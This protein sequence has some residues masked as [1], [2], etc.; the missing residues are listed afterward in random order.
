MKANETSVAAPA[1]R[2]VHNDTT[3]EIMDWPDGCVHEIV[4]SIPFGDQYEYS[5]SLNDFGHNQ[6][7]E[8]FWEQMDFMTPHLLRILKPGRVACVHVKDRIR[9]GNVTGKGM[10]TLDPFSDECSAHF[11]QHGF[12]LMG[13]ITIDTDVVR[14][15]A[16]TYRLGYSEM[17][18]DG[19]KMGCG[20]PE[21]VLLLRKP[22][23]DKDRSYADEPVTREPDKD[24]SAGLGYSLSQWQ[25]DAAGLWRSSGD[26]L[27][28]AEVLRALP[29]DQIRSIWRE[30]SAGSIYSLNVH[31][32]K[33]QE[34]LA[35]GLLPTGWMLFAPVSR[36]PDIWSDIE[37]IRTLNT[38]NVRQGKEKHV[39]PLQLD[40]IERLIRRYSMKGEI[41]FDPF[42][43]IGSVPVQAL[44][45]GRIGWGCELSRDYFEIACGYC[46]HAA[47]ADAMPT[48]FDLAEYT[49]EDA[50]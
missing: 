1:W 34:L 11:R 2:M 6:G 15:N 48:L 17:C 13:R 18:K 16:Q 32:T 42:A 50:A 24:G 5:P 41:V 12:E 36:N 7:N 30:H 25:I 31:E 14:E 47:A 40:I 3:L 4:T 19:T 20:A 44:R 27:P 46:E 43:G 45:M 33:C 29:L 9:F 26:R 10:Y 38:D 8:A 49:L 21:Y 28:S 22:Q 37:R 23:S 39:C 35:A